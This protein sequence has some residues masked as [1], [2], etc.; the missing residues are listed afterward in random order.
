MS[1]YP[2]SSHKKG[3]SPTA[4]TTTTAQ[5][6][7]PFGAKHFHM[8]DIQFHSCENFFHSYDK[9]FHINEPRFI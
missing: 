1:T 8:V 4:N 3:K 7:F 5:Y 6:Q 9:H 2:Q